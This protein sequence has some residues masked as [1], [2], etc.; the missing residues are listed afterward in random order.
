MGF[1]RSGMHPKAL[2]F[3]FLVES[4][5]KTNLVLYISSFDQ[6][7]VGFFVCTFNVFSGVV[8]NDWLVFHQFSTVFFNNIFLKVVF[9]TWSLGSHMK[10]KNCYHGKVCPLS[11]AY[12]TNIHVFSVVTITLDLE[13]CAFIQQPFCILRL[14]PFRVPLYPRKK[15]SLIKCNDW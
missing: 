2:F 6:K 11:K 14:L 3:L 10:E 13:L 7:W 9:F 8:K 1:P 4:V 15:R 5:S 12:K